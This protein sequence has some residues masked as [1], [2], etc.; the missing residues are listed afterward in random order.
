MIKKDIDQDIDRLMK[1]KEEVDQAK[2]LK[3]LTPDLEII[4]QAMY[5]YLVSKNLRQPDKYYFVVSHE[6]GEYIEG[7]R[8]QSLK[9]NFRL[10]IFNA[11]L[12]RINFLN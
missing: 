1:I 10:F 2:L 3:I 4:S 7:F 11:K 5:D 12:C 9:F 8:G 6:A